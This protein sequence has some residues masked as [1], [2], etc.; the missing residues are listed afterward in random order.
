M[1]KKHIYVLISLISLGSLLIDAFVYAT[2]VNILYFIL[3]YIL[4]LL[5]ASLIG[6]YISRFLL[7]VIVFQ[8]LLTSLIFPKYSY[9]DAEREIL[10]IYNQ[11]QVFN[12]KPTTA[13]TSIH[14]YEI[15]NFGYVFEIEYQGKRVEVIVNPNNLAEYGILGGNH[16]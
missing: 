10:E 16:D 12:L 9:E 14:F 15:V 11:E 5:S 13:L 6:K 1:Q 3:I 7:V 4:S 8:I 2:T